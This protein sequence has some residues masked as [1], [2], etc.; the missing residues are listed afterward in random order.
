MKD[1]GLDVLEVN[2][3]AVDGYGICS[4]LYSA[5]PTAKVR[6]FFSSEIRKIS[7]FCMLGSIWVM[8]GR[9]ISAPFVTNLTAP[10]STTTVLS[11]IRLFNNKVICEVRDFSQGL[12][13]ADDITMLGL[14]VIK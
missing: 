8:P 6:L 1:D 10:I 12:P 7:P 2:T 11:P 9:I 14:K 4:A 5:F 3:S 13:Q